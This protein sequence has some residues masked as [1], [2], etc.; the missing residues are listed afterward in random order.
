M[1]TPTPPTPEILTQIANE[2]FEALVAKGIHAMLFRIERQGTGYR[3]D[4]TKNL[5]YGYPIGNFTKGEESVESEEFQD[6][7]RGGSYK[8]HVAGA[9]D[10]GDITFNAYFDVNVGKPDIEG[11][12]NSTVFTP[13]FALI[14]ARKKSDTMLE[15][16]FS[17]GVN[18]LGGN[19]IKGDYGK[20]IATS[21]KFKIS[22]KPTYG[23]KVGE[24]A[25]SL[26]RAGAQ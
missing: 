22:G 9:I 24:I 15:G 6:Q 17:A 1:S 19:D 12:V 2:G 7:I 21:L 14:L 4:T 13:Q 8:N 10:A 18:Y 16:F 26:Y 20:V 23:K 5:L 11:V 3:T 25:M